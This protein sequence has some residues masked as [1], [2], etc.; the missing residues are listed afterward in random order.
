MATRPRIVRAVI[1]ADER[2][3]AAHEQ[4]VEATEFDET[5]DEASDPLDADFDE[6]TYLRAFPDIAEAVRRGILT[7]GLEHFHKAGRAEMR[8]EK[9]E[10]RALLAAHAGPAA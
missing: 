10:Y 1:P 6:A 7:S 9:A 2:D 3:T 5:A 8:L 4:E